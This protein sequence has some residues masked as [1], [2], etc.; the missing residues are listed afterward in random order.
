M[1][2]RLYHTN[3]ERR[4]EHLPD[5]T[6]GVNRNRAAI[7]HA[8]KGVRATA[9]YSD[10]PRLCRC[11]GPRLLPFRKQERWPCAYRMRVCLMLH[12]TGR[13]VGES[14]TSNSSP[15]TS[16]LGHWIAGDVL[17][18]RRVYVCV[19]GRR[20]RNNGGRHYIYT[21]YLRRNI[22]VLLLAAGLLLLLLLRRL[23]W[24]LPLLLLL[25]LLL[26]LAHRLCQHAQLL[27]L[28][29]KHVSDREDAISCQGVSDVPQTAVLRRPRHTQHLLTQ[30]HGCRGH[31]FLLDSCVWRPTRGA[32]ARQHPC[33]R[34]CNGRPRVA[35]KARNRSSAWCC[36]CHH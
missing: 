15:P 28:E 7:Y 13:P 3:L 22:D 23:T 26:L 24:L 35:G 30:H 32:A 5:E 17:G 11:N 31:R 8:D 19:S 20:R 21:Y 10:I 34:R 16:M 33:V 1:C 4:W 14:A 25:L 6:A 12:R 29:G 2:L 18:W 36:R 9:G 27:W